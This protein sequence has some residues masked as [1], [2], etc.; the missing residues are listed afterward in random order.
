[1]KKL[2]LMQRRMI[3]TNEQLWSSRA[4]TKYTKS[5]VSVFAVFYCLDWFDSDLI[6]YFQAEGKRDCNKSILFKKGA[7]NC[8]TEISFRFPIQMCVIYRQSPIFSL[9]TKNI[10]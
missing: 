5:D 8:C 9:V 1:M 4:W 3:S 2:V 10:L 6:P 7:I